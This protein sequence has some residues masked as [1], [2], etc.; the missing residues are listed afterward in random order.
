MNRSILTWRRERSA[1]PQSL[2][3]LRVMGAP[4]AQG[5]RAAARATVIRRMTNTRRA[6]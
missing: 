3:R 5:S 6:A 1:A 2:R 4:I